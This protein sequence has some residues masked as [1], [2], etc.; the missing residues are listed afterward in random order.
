MVIMVLFAATVNFIKKN[1]SQATYNKN[2]ITM[3]NSKDG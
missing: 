2:I 3:E 1:S